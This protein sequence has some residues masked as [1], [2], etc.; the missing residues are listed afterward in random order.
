[1]AAVAIL[2][3]AVLPTLLLATSLP[4]PNTTSNITKLTDL[5]DFTSDDGGKLV[6][7]STISTSSSS[8]ATVS[9]ASTLS[10]TSS[11][12]SSTSS[13]PWEES[14]DKTPLPELCVFRQRVYGDTGKEG[15]FPG[16]TAVACEQTRIIS[17]LCGWE[18]EGSG[19]PDYYKVIVKKTSAGASFP[20]GREVLTSRQCQKE[21][22]MVDECHH[23]AFVE[24]GQPFH[25][26]F[27]LREVRCKPQYACMRDNR[28]LKVV[29]GRKTCPFHEDE[30]AAR[31]RNYS[32][33]CVAAS[34]GPSEQSD[35]PAADDEGL[36]AYGRDF[37]FKLQLVMTNFFGV[38]L[39]CYTCS[40][41]LF[42]CRLWMMELPTLPERPE[43]QA[44]GGLASLFQ[45][46]QDPEGAG[47]PGM[48]PSYGSALLSADTA[49]YP[50]SPKPLPKKKPKKAR[51]QEIRADP[52]RAD[53]NPRVCDSRE[54]S[55]EEGR[56][57]DAEHGDN[58]NQEE[59]SGIEEVI[60]KRK[61]KP[62]ESTS[63]ESSS[64]RADSTEIAAHTS[65]PEGSDEGVPFQH[66]DSQVSEEEGCCPDSE[67]CT[68]CLTCGGTGE[69]KWFRT[70]GW[71]TILVAILMWLP[72][73]AL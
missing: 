13:S 21:C 10:S 25:S 50:D 54:V 42:C 70:C 44:D 6:N 46:W 31:I 47:D 3:V 23:F 36:M 62:N 45:Q 72:K 9:T 43:T 52:E 48:N 28:D 53:S 15:I 57:A 61:K 4:D 26:C 56:W 18:G 22:Q 65:G 27:L 30:E 14:E 24:K 12:G 1:M 69:W 73:D 51:T 59:A 29:S 2:Q 19:C 41:L 8:L 37:L 60:K 67:A 38:M 49:P 7:S 17:V 33:Y 55:L 34:K 66:T 35:E 68:W 40:G 11:S 5:T 20:S 16:L 58:A 39:C 32:A 63:A 71:L 64:L